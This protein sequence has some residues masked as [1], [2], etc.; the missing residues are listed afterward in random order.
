VFRNTLKLN[1]S[2]LR[3]GPEAFKAFYTDDLH[4]YSI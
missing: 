4:I 2:F 1:E 3:I